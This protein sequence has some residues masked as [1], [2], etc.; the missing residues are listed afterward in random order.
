MK[1]RLNRILPFFVALTLS[2]FMIACE[3]EEM[4]DRDHMG[5]T[6]GLEQMP[7]DPGMGM[8]PG[9]GTFSSWDTDANRDLSEDEFGAGAHQG[10][11]WTM[12]D[13]DA[14]T[15]LDQEEFDTAFGQEDWYEEG[16]FDQWDADGDGELS[17]EEW[18]SGVFQAMDENNDGRI[19]EDEFSD[20][21]FHHRM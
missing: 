18:H 9:T 5:S 11:A 7:T 6:E 15:T 8:A 4:D 10:A 14:N 1:T 20:G 19:T 3:D 13:T 17:R 12:W 16:S 2:V 21:L